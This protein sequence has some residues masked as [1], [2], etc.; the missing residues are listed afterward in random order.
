MR[1]ID[2]DLHETFAP[3]RDVEPTADEIAR[4]LAAADELRSPRSLP[5]RAGGRRASSR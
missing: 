2:P 3:L 5:A 4:V 1:T